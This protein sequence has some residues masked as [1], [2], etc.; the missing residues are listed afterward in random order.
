MFAKTGIPDAGAD[1][2]KNKLGRLSLGTIIQAI[3]K[4]Q[5][6]PEWSIIYHNSRS[7]T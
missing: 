5:T 3:N 7:Y 2:R 4:G 6:P 1:G